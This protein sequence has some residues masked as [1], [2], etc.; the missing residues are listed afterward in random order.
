MESRLL[1]LPGELRNKI[2]EYALTIDD[3]I[4]YRED[5]LGVGWLCLH[6]QQTE[7]DVEELAQPQAAGA[8]R[9]ELED[10]APARKRRRLTKAVRTTKKPVVAARKMRRPAQVTVNGHVVANQL[11]F[12]NNQLRSETRA[13]VIRY[14]DIHILEE[15][16]HLTE[17]IDSVVGHK[18]IWIQK[19]VRR[20]QSKRK[21]R[22]PIKVKSH[23]AMHPRFM[24]HDYLP[25]VSL[26]GDAFFMVAGVIH[27]FGRQDDSFL[28]RLTQNVNFQQLVRSSTG[29]PK[30]SP[31]TKKFP[32]DKKFDEA[33]TRRYCETND[34]VQHFLLPTAP[35]GIEGL[36]AIAKEWIENGY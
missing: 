13:L 4:C 35:N 20:V 21:S 26:D 15:Y 9:E 5:K 16:R 27:E 34:F 2:F 19:I 18:R 3:G 6:P 8:S 33:A 31:Y 25:E 28:S 17:F 23:E 7:R 12:V 10:E 14:N 22:R 11:Q 36:V 24:I 30:L 1:Q 32:W 29:L